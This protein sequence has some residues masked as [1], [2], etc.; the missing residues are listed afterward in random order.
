MTIDL[1]TFEAWALLTKE[2]KT[3]TFVDET[4][5]ASFAVLHDLAHRNED[6]PPCLTRWLASTWGCSAQSVKT[7]ARIFE[8]FGA[9]EIT[10]DVPLS[11]WNALM[12]TDD[13]QAWLE[14][15][16]AEGLS[17]R[18]VRDIYGSLKGKHLSSCQFAGEVIVKEWHV[19][20]GTVTVAGLP[21]SGEQPAR[22]HAAM[23]EVL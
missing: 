20:T 16:L 23:R 15:A 11:L 1:S 22:V 3:E 14:R 4:R 13:P 9:D 6:P 5:L 12:E 18:D 17:A 21:I 7:L 19:P 10:P 2:R 8:T